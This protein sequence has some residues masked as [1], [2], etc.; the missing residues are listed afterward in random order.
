MPISKFPVIQPD[1]NDKSA[2]GEISN[3]ELTPIF[4]GDFSYSVNPTVWNVWTNK[5]TVTSELSRGKFSTGAAANQS[6]GV[7]SQIPVKYYPGQGVAA[8]FTGAFTTG[9]T[10]SEQ[11]I[12]L[13]DVSDGFFFGYNGPTFGILHRRAGSEAARTFTVTAGNTTAAGSC[14]I[15]LNGATK[16]F[17]FTDTSGNATITANEIAAQDY[18]AT[19]F[20]W[21]ATARGNTVI[22]ISYDAGVK[23]GTYSLAATTATATVS[24]SITGVAPTDNW[25]PQ[26][27]WNG[28]KANGTGTLQTIDWTK[29]NVFQIKAQWLGFGAVRFYIEEPST[30]KLVLVHTLKYANTVTVPSIQTP[31]IPLSARV[32]NTTNTS[33]IIM[34]SASMAGFVEGRKGTGIGHFGKASSKIGVSTQQP[35]LSLHNVRIF[36]GKVNRGRIYVLFADLSAEGNKPAT[37]RY[38]VNQTLVD[39]SFSDLVPTVSIASV[40]T[41]ATS[42]SGGIEE[43]GA[44]LAKSA[45]RTIQMAGANF[46]LNPGDT[47]TVTGESG[48]SSDVT[49]AFHWEEII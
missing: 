24:T 26:T 40:D 16:V 25:I 14:T 17:N 39:S 33:D 45:S 27:S 18:S 19:G 4:Q 2:F 7:T 38:F 9:V 22:F 37:I 21:K 32:V 44:T 48:A 11:T 13:G 23:A 36:N 46:I 31:T 49:V 6:A 3:A 12:G 30:G 41:S 15:T 20:G 29:G 1:V 28:D 5:G 8:R 35:L 34:Y 43:Y 47:L 10:G 42:S